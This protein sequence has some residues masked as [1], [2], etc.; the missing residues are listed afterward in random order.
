MEYKEFGDTGKRL[1][2]ITLGTWSIGGTGWG[3]TNI[4]EAEAAVHKML[5]YGVNAIDT[6]PV[7][8]FPDY[9]KPDYGYGYAESFIGKTIQKKRKDIF[10]VTKCGLNFDRGQGPASMYKSM[11]EKEIIL[12]CEESLKRL[13]TEYIDLLLVHWPDMKTSMEEVCEAMRKLKKQGKILHYGLSNFT[14]EDV[15][16]ADEMLHVGAVQLPYS[17]VDTKKE[18]ELQILREK[19]IATMTYGSLGSGIL[20]G[21]YRS[22]PEF[23]ETDMRSSFYHFFKNPIFNQIQSL[24][25]IMD[26]IAANHKVPVSTVA[27]QWSIH[28]AFVDTAILGVSKPQHAKQNC[29]AFTWQIT[30][31]EV[32]ILD[33]AI[34]EYLGRGKS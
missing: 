24:L 33:E 30:D 3:I 26:E 8:G 17:M 1:S 31:E 25:C 19:G 27:I 15:C 11:N 16:K 7:Y 18:E 29:E 9:S 2:A 12:G 28:K 14:L 6:A 4:Q 34:D 10:L 22:I 21:A 13:Q 23:S 20:T 5:D 32:K